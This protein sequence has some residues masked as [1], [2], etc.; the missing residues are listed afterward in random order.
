MFA[1][2]EQNCQEVIQKF[3]AHEVLTVEA[4]DARGE[5]RFGH[6]LLSGVDNQID[7]TTGTLKC[8]ANLTPEGENLMVPG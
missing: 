5:K 4:Y 6:G 7:P 1:I 2:P 8:R 3:D